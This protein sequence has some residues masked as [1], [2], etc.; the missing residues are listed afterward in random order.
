MVLMINKNIFTN[1]FKR[2]KLFIVLLLSIAGYVPKHATKLRT[3]VM[4]SSLAFFAYLSIYHPNNFNIAII[5]FITSLILYMGFITLVLKKNGY[6]RW[7][8]KKFGGEKKGY[9]VYEG[10]LGFLFFNTAVSL[11]YVASSSPGNLFNFVNRNI[12]LVIVAILSLT[13]LVVKILAAKVTSIDIY[14]WKDMFLGRK[15]CKFVVTG[16]YKYFSNPMYGVGQ[17]QIYAIAIFYGSI[18]GLIAAVLY[19]T[20]VFTFYYTVEKKFI[21]RVYLKN[22]SSK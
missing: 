11:G 18:Y 14:Y 12:L 8:I 7:F 2:I 22:S 13:G 15:I 16:P 5:Y 9:L 10:I 21:K 3:I 1:F 6:S 17:L 20:S 4:L 19:Q